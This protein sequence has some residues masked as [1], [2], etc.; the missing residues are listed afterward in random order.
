M[1]KVLIMLFLFFIYLSIHSQNVNYVKLLNKIPTE[2]SL[3]DTVLKEYLNN[4]NI[5]NRFKRT[6]YQ[7]FKINNKFIN[8][9]NNIITLLIYESQGVGNRAFLISFSIDGKII[10]E[11]KI[12]DAFDND[13]LSAPDF[14]YFYTLNDKQITIKY[15]KSTPTKSNT[16][17]ITHK[18]S[19]YYSYININNSGYFFELSKE[20]FSNKE[21][22]FPEV[23]DKLLIKSDLTNL[24]K[25]DLAIIRNEIFAS[26]GYIFKTNRFKSYFA[27]QE[28]YKPQFDN[29]DKNLSDNEKEN[30][31]LIRALEKW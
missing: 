21:R 7:V 6:T 24:T 4:K 17:Y 11:K 15:R 29:V 23:S 28:W 9:E 10:D 5:L 31:K 2:I 19:I 25:D 27:E 13:D 3:T 1:K 30:I 18:D 26:K 20:K 14:D 22:L 12:M 16:K 8:N